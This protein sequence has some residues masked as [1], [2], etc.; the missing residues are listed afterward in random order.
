MF[1]DPSGGLACSY[2]SREPDMVVTSA[3]G[4]LVTLIP[5]PKVSID[6]DRVGAQLEDPIN[7]TAGSTLTGVQSLAP[8]VHRDLIGEGDRLLWAPSHWARMSLGDSLL[9]AEHLTEAVD[10]AIAGLAKGRR[11]AAEVSGGFDSAV[12]SSALNAGR[13]DLAALVHLA[14]PEDDANELVYA[15]AVAETMKRRLSVAPL[16]ALM[17][18]LSD[19]AHLQTDVVPSIS[20]FD[21]AAEAAVIAACRQAG[22]EALFTGMG[23]DAV[24]WSA[25][26]HLILADRIAR[27]G[28][29]SLWNAATVDLARWTQLSIPAAVARAVGAR[30]RRPHLI[31]RPPSWLGDPRGLAVSSSVDQRSRRRSTGKT[32]ADHRPGP[33]AGLPRLEPADECFGCRSSPPFPACG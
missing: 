14:A 13:H 27:L 20:S 22:A 23:G 15:Q 1:R 19:I 7:L 6:W 28:L 3:A 4:Q 21:P 10:Q 29:F 12:V 16:Q 25:P 5:P 26:S 24:F 33:N 18:E 9:T 2:W 30:F 11:V 8:G 32:P 17:L 31:Y